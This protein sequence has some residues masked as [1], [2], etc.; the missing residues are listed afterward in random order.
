MRTQLGVKI[1]LAIS[2]LNWSSEAKIC[3][4]ELKVLTQEQVLGLQISMGDTSLVVAVVKTTHE[5]CEE[6]TALI[7]RKGT[8]VGDVVEELTA[9]SD[10]QDNIL[11]LPLDGTIFHI[12]SRG[13]LD[14]FNNIW[15][16]ELTAHLNLSH[17][18]LVDLLILDVVHE[19]K[20]HL[21]SGA[22]V[23]GQ[24]D[25]ATGSLTKCLDDTVVSNLFWHLY[26]LIDVLIF[27]IIKLMHRCC[28]NKVEI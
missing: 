11:T 21:G 1:S 26:F 14:L 5:L 18:Q 28:L 25:L 17:E 27:I 7:L 6:V 20:S 9:F 10:L 15:V 19:L 22:S 4:L 12:V 2:A 23:T 8:G 24:L 16:V 13:I 3:D